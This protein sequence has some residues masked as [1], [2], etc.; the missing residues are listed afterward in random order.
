MHLSA[1]SDSPSSR[2]LKSVVVEEMKLGAGVR[3]LPAWQAASRSVSSLRPDRLAKAK[4]TI[5]HCTKQKRCITTIE[6]QI[7]KANQK[8]DMCVVQHGGITR[9][10]RVMFYTMSTAWL[11]L[12][13]L[14]LK[15][16][17]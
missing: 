6:V 9:N 16:S 12:I 10:A 3:L 7:I 8:E 4:M 2:F 13:L 14:F 5:A 17:W 11:K 1:K 15:R